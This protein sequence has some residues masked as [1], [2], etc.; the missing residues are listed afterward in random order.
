MKFFKNWR[1]VAGWVLSATIL[2][3]LAQTL[4]SSWGKVAESGF[5]F[6]FNVP[7]LALSLFMRLC[8]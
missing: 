7:L 2:V 3:F 6:Q 8:G 5:R 1:R 4:W